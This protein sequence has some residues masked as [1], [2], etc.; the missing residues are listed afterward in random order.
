MTLIRYLEII[1]DG[2]I[3][4][5]KY[6]NVTN[7]GLCVCV[8]PESQ[9][10]NIYEHTSAARVSDRGFCTC[11]PVTCTIVVGMNKPHSVHE[12]VTAW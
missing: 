3:N 10:L 4:T 8:C 1:Q 11:I 9:L 12:E 6:A 2:N 7:Q 5:K